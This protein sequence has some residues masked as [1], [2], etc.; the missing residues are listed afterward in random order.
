M[1]VVTG[2]M[3]VVTCEECKSWEPP[4]KDNSTSGRCRKNAP[5]V[6]IK[7]DSVQ[8]GWPHSKASDWCSEG[9]K[10]GYVQKATE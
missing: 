3:K 1:V 9:E 7:D 5:V 4:P 10:I 2:T 6:W 8:S